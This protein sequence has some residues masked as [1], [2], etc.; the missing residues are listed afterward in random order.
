RE[1]MLLHKLLTRYSYRDLCCLCL[2]WL[3]QALSRIGTSTPGSRAISDFTRSAADVKPYSGITAA[4]RRA[5]RIS[6]VPSLRAG[7]C[8]VSLTAPIEDSLWR[9]TI[10]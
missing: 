2:P 6:C 9:K 8:F 4:A 1:V 5:L 7:G 10:L 3:N